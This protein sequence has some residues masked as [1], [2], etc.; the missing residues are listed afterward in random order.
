M[1]LGEFSQALNSSRTEIRENIDVRFEDCDM[2]SEA[3]VMGNMCQTRFKSIS[4]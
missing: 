2:R 3:Y 1:T 4:T